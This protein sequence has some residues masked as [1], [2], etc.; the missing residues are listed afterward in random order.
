MG[1]TSQ[2]VGGSFWRTEGIFS[3]EKGINMLKSKQQ[4]S[5]SDKAKSNYYYKSCGARVGQ[6]AGK[7]RGKDKE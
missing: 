1:T 3:A 6:L 4:M 5:K 2:I 7:H